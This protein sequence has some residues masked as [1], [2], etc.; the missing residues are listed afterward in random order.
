MTALERAIARPDPVHEFAA[1]SPLDGLERRTVGFA[2]VLAQ[3]V[4]A[5]APAAAATTVILLVAGAAGGAT[6]PAVA[7]A[8][9][10]ALLVAGTVTQFTRRLAA[11]GSLYTYA[12]RGLGPTAGL[13]TGAA[14]IVGYAFI[15]VF[16]L[17]GG[18]HYLSMLLARVAPGVPAPLAAIVALVGEAAVLAVVLVRGIRLSARIALIVESVSVALI[19]TLLTALLVQIGPFDISAI[20]PPG[21]V[22]ASAVAAGAVLALTAFVGFESSA[23]LGVEARAPLR[24]IPRAIVGTVLVAGALYLLAAYTQVAGFAAIGRDLVSSAAPIDELAGA[25]GLAPWAAAADVGIAASFLACAIASTTALT[26]VL[27]AMGRD[28]VGPQWLGRTHP[29]H[30]TPIGA[31]WPTVTAIAALPVVIVALGVRPWDAMGAVIVISAVGYITAYAIVCAAAPV[32]LRRIGE[33]TVA[34]TVVAATAAIAIVGCLAVYLVVEAQQGNPGVWIS[35]GLGGLAGALI[36]WRRRSG[37]PLDGIGGYDEPTASHVLGG[38]AR[39][40]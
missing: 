22:S 40:G 31:V 37:A 39:D 13:A 29:R 33:T 1:T 2:D 35:L 7:L 5:V 4:A 23:T 32:F 30:R 28:G 8:T 34:A 12:A 10:L 21:G 25:F 38:V 9:V 20:L 27:F 11:S 36:A 26:R 14:I 19:V 16:A 17:L 3:S 18:A 6:L 15:S 24:N